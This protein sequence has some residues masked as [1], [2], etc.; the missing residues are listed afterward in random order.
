MVEKI[1]I[2]VD[3]G[4]SHIT[5]AA[6]DIPS[7]S[8][9]DETIITEKVDNQ[10]PASE[11]LDAWASAIEKTIEKIPTQKII[12]IGFAMPGPFDYK[13]GIA[14]FERVQ[15]FESLFGINV[16]EELRKRLKVSKDLPFR[17][18]NDAMAFAIGEAWAGEGAEYKK[19]IALTL[20]TGFG[21]A[22]LYEGKPVTAGDT[23]PATGM[24]WH[25]PFKNG[26]ADDY[27]STRWFLSENEKRSGKK[28][29]GVWELSEKIDEETIVGELFEEFG[30]NMGEIILSHAK[31]FGAEVIVLGG[32]ISN[33]YYLF[34]NAFEEKLDEGGLEI[35]VLI[36][37][38]GEDA[39]ILGSAKLLDD[40]FFAK[41][42]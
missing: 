21:S 30:A 20:G 31:K 9:I 5:C 6:V 28:A 29:S 35:P 32:N 2:G 34:G 26:I 39:A 7:K 11:I 33:A 10:A 18:I 19:V 36:S 38:L 42:Y 22:F 13:N 16:S 1:A 8:I 24:V 15:K 25:V 27:I 4:G 37:E 14:L 12:G 40:V 41:L 3:I 17:Y 23:V